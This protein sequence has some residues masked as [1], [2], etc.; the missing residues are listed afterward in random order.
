MYQAQDF[1]AN[2]S[3]S[4]HSRHWLTLVERGSR[5]VDKLDYFIRR[6]AISQSE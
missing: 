1:S 2:T 3:S 4:A 5:A 6:W